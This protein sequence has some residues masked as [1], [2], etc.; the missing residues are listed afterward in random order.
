MLHDNMQSELFVELSNKQ[1][2]FVAGGGPTLGIVSDATEYVANTA[3]TSSGAAA[4]PIG[5]TSNGFALPGEIDSF[6]GQTSLGASGVPGLAIPAALTFPSIAGPRTAALTQ[7]A[8][9]ASGIPGLPPLP[10]GLPNV[11]GLPGLPGA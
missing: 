8:Q 1:Q 10:T 9:Q 4:G 2:Q 11:P 5:A 6:G 7:P 3:P